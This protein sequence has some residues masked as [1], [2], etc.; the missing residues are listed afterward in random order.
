MI[1]FEGQLEKLF[2]IV[3]KAQSTV[4]LQGCIH[5]ALNGRASSADTDALLQ[6]IT[7]TIHAPEGTIFICDMKDIFIIASSL[8]SRT[9]Y[10][11]R[12]L[13]AA[14]YG[15]GGLVTA[16]R[17]RFYDYSD[18]P[19]LVRLVRQM[20]VNEAQHHQQTK[21]EQ[22]TARRNRLRQDIMGMA[23]P[24]ELVASLRSRRDERDH[25]ELMLV[26]D[27]P[28]SRQLVR[29]ALMP[30]FSVS[31]VSDGRS[32]VASY[33]RIAPDVLFLDIGLPDISGLD[34][35]KKILSIDPQA[36]VVMLSGKGDRDN[37]AKAMEHGA[38]GFVGKPFSKAKL[39]EYI[40]RSAASSALK[41]LQV[42]EFCRHQAGRQE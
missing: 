35:L 28:F 26:D 30:G 6:L 25:V 41:G 13:I 7:K 21:Q 38:K 10:D 17:I 32:C 11:L 1:I 12:A 39:L 16:E 42:R 8:T 33:S 37:I 34:V 4:A 19:A 23:I 14:T 3:E 36:Y 27:D 40:G 2:E 20:R 31:Q 9:C 24:E 15:G 29:M 5:L 18:W 22:D